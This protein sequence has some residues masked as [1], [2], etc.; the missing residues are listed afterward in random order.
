MFAI[1]KNPH[2]VALALSGIGLVVSCAVVYRHT[3]D[4]KQHFIRRF[5]P[6]PMI[7]PQTAV[8]ETPDEAIDPALI[9]AAVHHFAAPAQW[10]GHSLFVPDRYVICD[11]KPF[12]VKVTGSDQCF[13]KPDLYRRAAMIPDEWFEHNHLIKWGVKTVDE[14]PDHDGFSNWAEWLWKTDPNDANP[15]P[16]YHRELYL[17][18]LIK[19]G[20]LKLIFEAYDQDSG[21]Q[22]ETTFQ[23]NTVGP[24]HATQFLKVGDAIANSKWRIEKFKQQP[25]VTFGEAQEVSE[26]EVRNTETGNFLALPLGKIVDMSERFA[27]FVYK[28]PIGSST[29]IQVKEGAEF[30]LLPKADERYKLVQ[31]NEVEAVIQ[32]PAGEKIVIGMDRGS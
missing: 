3:L 14:D 2:L 8:E 22:S 31:I 23:V 13:P 18:K 28:W 6:T 11:W 7:R 29:E 5:E 24:T 25:K 20:S 30:T 12:P 9:E 1:G 32:S 21:K 16:P 4:F 15:H 27:N 17:K 19:V 26:L 10:L